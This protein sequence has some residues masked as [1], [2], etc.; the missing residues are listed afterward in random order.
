[1]YKRLAVGVFIIILSML[2]FTFLLPIEAKEN[3]N[4]M[5]IL[6]SLTKKVNVYSSLYMLDD[7][8]KN[9]TID[10]ITS[11][12]L[13]ENFIRAERVNQQGGFFEKVTWIRFS[14]DNRSIQRD[15]LLEL[16]FPI[17]Y[18]IDIFSEDES[19]ITELQSAGSNHP[20]TEKEIEHRNFVF[21]LA[22]DHGKQKTYYVRVL[23]PGAMHPPI[24][25]W[26]SNSF[27]EKTQ[28][29]FSLLG[30]FYGMISVMILYNLFLYFS[31]R[32]SSY[33]YYVLVITSTLLGQLA[34]NGLAFQYLWPNSPSWNVI[35]TP[36]L[37]SVACIFILLFTRSFLDTDRYY[38]RFKMIS[39]VLMSLNVVVIMVLF[40]S[41]IAA[42]NIMLLSTLSTFFMVLSV[43]FICLKR[44]ARQARFFIVGWLFFLIGVFVTIL[45]RASVIPYSI[46][47]D[48]AGQAT[49][50]IEVVLLSL[51][52]ADKINIMRAEKEQAE[53]ELKVSRELA[54]ESLQ[55]ADELKDEFLA[56]TSHELRTPLYGMIGI[57]ESLRDGIT[58]RVS[59]GMSDQLSIIIHSGNRLTHLIND[60]LDFSKLKHDSL[61]VYLKPVDLARITDVIFMICQPLVKEGT[62]KLVNSI[63]HSLPIVIADQNRLQQIFYN[64]IGNAIKYTTNGSVVVSAELQAGYVKINV[65]DT[66]RGIP[67]HQLEKIFAPFTQGDVSLSRE[68]GGTGIG[69]SITKQLVALHGGEIEVKSKVGVGSTFSFTLPIQVD[70]EVV[71]DVVLSEDIY[72]EEGFE[73]S[74]PDIQFSSKAV[75]ILVAD[76][77][78]VNL[79]VLMNQLSLE[80]Y[81]VITAS[82]GEEVLRIVEEQSIELLILDIMMPKVSGFE[83]CKRLRKKYSLMELPILMLTAKSQ[84]RDKITSFEVGANDYLSKPCDKEELIAR[85]KTLVRLKD[86]NR[87]LQN[88]NLR[89][90]EKVKERTEALEVA[91]I[92][93][94]TMN[95]DLIVMETA[96]RELLANIAHELGT[97]VT[98]IHGYMQAIQQG[99]VTSDDSY[100]GN[101]VYDKIKVLNRL[102]DDLFDLSKLEAGQTSLNMK[103]VNVYEWL[104]RTFDK[105]EMDV[106]QSERKPCLLENDKHMEEYMCLIDTERMDQVISNLVRNAV[107]YTAP[108]DGVLSISAKISAEDY[109]LVIKIEDN[110]YGIFEENLSVLFE[111]F[112]KGVPSPT[113]IRQSGTGLGLAIVKEIIHSHNGEVWAESKVNEGSIFYLSIPIQKEAKK[114]T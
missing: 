11:E 20:F 33:L 62:V 88:V 27:I 85:V 34:T 52:L 81:T 46:L 106:L 101:L 58:G 103:M 50:A 32:I 49:L 60:I 45:E 74:T 35:A 17:I 68:V 22:V 51:A 8:K 21:N 98:L 94:T 72:V 55:K 107:K 86:L 9:L 108:E 63:D 26:N 110:G 43:A 76:D 4:D 12:E 84:V 44:G 61:D 36:F 47:T 25:I 91:N 80:G 70:Q 89:L 37:V 29:E 13:K 75:K 48:Y 66:G 57:A 96:R 38:Y 100:F 56:I 10:D 105:F 19:G 18:E 15:W 93:L 30:F 3:K 77:E 31:L 53:L 102:I 14:V 65:S 6:H 2:F 83:V 24:N 78:P 54:M 97:P 1:M 90:E 5:L 64:L 28:M 113:A 16:A 73:V 23:G 40:I 67:K 95:E 82:N 109:Q 42:L 41:P 111:R 39:Y 79:Q 114:V 7:K 92:D 71:A 99:L 112:Y 104:E 87:E 69:L 59:K